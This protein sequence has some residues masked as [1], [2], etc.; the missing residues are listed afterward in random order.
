[1]FVYWTCFICLIQDNK[2]FCGD[3][4]CVEFEINDFYLYLYIPRA[5]INHEKLTKITIKKKSNQQLPKDNLI[6]ER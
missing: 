5:I 3:S 4:Y 1:M 6:K 2:S